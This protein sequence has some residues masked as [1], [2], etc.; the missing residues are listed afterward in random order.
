M[1]DYGAEKIVALLLGSV[2]GHSLWGGKNVGGGVGAIG[3]DAGGLVALDLGKGAGGI[4]DAGVVG[5]AGGFFA[6][7]A[8]VALP[9]ISP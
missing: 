8:G 5:E 9:P 3:G 4:E 6:D 2:G 7:E 1:A